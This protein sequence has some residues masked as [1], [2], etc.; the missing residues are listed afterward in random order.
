VILRRAAPLVLHWRA[1]QLVVENYVTRRCAPAVVP[2]L[3]V[4]DRA[5]SGTRAADLARVLPVPPSQARRF[6]RAL[7]RATLLERVAP[8]QSALSVWDQWLPHAGVLHFGSK[9]EIYPPVRVAAADFLRR[10]LT[11]PQPAP[12][13]T[14]P[15]PRRP[16]PPPSLGAVP[17]S[18]ALTS[19][20]TWRRFG[21]APFPLDAVGTLAGL[22][23][24]VQRWARDTAGGRVALKTSPSGGGMH[25]GEVYLAAFNVRGL[26]RGLYHYDAARHALARVSAAKAPF[27]P[28]RYLPAQ[29]CYERASAVF[30]MTA[31]VERE[32]WKYDSPRAY[33]AMLLDAGHLC[34]TFCLVATALGLAPSVPWRSPTLPSNATPASTAFAKLHSM[35]R[36]WGRDLGRASHRSM[37]S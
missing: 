26:R 23:W 27:T 2:V 4:L 34:Q 12:T 15:P 29:P 20:R 8:Q 24:G 9:D 36:G 32:R 22:T 30:L 10:A 1:G 5:A 6:V 33:R 3:E 37:G 25:P 11:S 19:R 17:L 13:K 28:S 16:L 14:Y 18:D 21:R 7:E 35:P 31:V